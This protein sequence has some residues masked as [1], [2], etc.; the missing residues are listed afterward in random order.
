MLYR[1]KPTGKVLPGVQMTI[2]EETDCFVVAYFGDNRRDQFVCAFS[3]ETYAPLE[4]PGESS[5]WAYDPKQALY[6]D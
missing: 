4:K 3:K 5:R 6:N 1:A 2:Y